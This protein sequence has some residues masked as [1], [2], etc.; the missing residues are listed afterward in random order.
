M[1]RTT[2]LIFL[3]VLGAALAGCSWTRT[4]HDPIFREDLFKAEPPRTLAIAPLDNLSKDEE[5]GE[6]MR[7]ALYRALAPLAYDDVELDEVDRFI[8]EKAMALNMRPEDLLYDYIASPDLADAVV[9]GEVT[10]VSRF[11]LFVYSQIRV[12]LQLV[13]YNTHTGEQL[14]L[15]HY[16]MHNPR[17]TLPTSIAGI[18]EAF[19]STFFHLRDRQLDVSLDAIAE[20]VAK[21]FPV[22]KG[23]VGR[24]RKNIETVEVSVAR[25]V[26]REGDKVVIRAL[27]SP[28]S[29]ATFSIGS[30]IVD[31]PMI[32]TDL[33]QYT[34]DYVVQPGDD[35]RYLFVTVTLAD[36][37]GTE[38]PTDFSA[39]EKPFAID[40]TRPVSY[41]ISSW[42]Q[43]PGR[44]GI[45][46]R[47]APVDPTDP[48][49]EN[50][51]KEFHV[52]RGTPGDAALQ[53]IGTTE[54]P[55]YKDEDAKV[56]VDY[57]YAVVAVDAAGNASEVRTRI[58]IT[59]GASSRPR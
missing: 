41:T 15:N 23:E 21:R 9:F 50:V 26:L 29:A 57:E 6:K 46:L 47:F 36:P 10:R 56:G 58:R 33:G 54:E 7:V 2:T 49:A 19:F 55:E 42:S 24:G 8:S 59:P 4:Q 45:V 39:H 53:P 27:G 34:A 44:D 14:Y 20:E 16:V 28:A 32:E 43:F 11:F 40:T 48:E 25:E 51:P 38:A 31:A 52:F 12:D 18:A 35:G 1:I 22:P 5:G 30:V 17:I 37:E 13:M 3:L